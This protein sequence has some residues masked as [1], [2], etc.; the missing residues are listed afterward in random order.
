MRLK[1]GEK[2]NNDSN[3]EISIPSDVEEDWAEIVRYQ[4]E[5][6]EEEKKKEKDRF[7]QKKKQLKETLDLQLKERNKKLLQEK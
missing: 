1:P 2:K 7:E 4:K 6:Y 3:S 5:V